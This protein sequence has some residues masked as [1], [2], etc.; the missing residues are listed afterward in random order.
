M[1]DCFISFTQA[2]L[3]FAQAVYGELK[4]HG[5][6]VFLAPISVRPGGWWSPTVL[7]NLRASPWVILLASRA[8]CSS[9]Y[10]QQECGAAIIAGKKIVP[11][12]WDMSPAALPGWLDRYQALDLRGATIQQLAMRIAEIARSIHSDKAVGNLIGIG[13]IFAALHFLSKD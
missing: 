10:V 3:R 9:A 8:S 5:L 11:V 1:P 13:L 12:V 2:D 7:D 6:D 4:Q